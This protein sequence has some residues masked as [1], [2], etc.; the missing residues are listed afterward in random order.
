MSRR[1]QDWHISGWLA[2]AL[3]PLVLPIALVAKLVS[4][5][6]TRDRS[7]AE[8]AGFLRDFI[9]GTGGEWDWDDFTSV[10][11]TNQRLDA[12]RIEADRIPLPI[13]QAGRIKL[14]ELL[15]RAEAFSIIGSELH[16]WWCQKCGSLCS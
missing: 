9:D 7:A 11:I 6:K 4:T 13:N 3:V 8:V 10:P 12:I 2:I 15:A 14:A 1:S 5:K 16:L